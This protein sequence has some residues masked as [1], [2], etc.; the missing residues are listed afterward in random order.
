MNFTAGM[1]WRHIRQRANKLALKR[2]HGLC[3]CCDF[4]QTKVRQMGLTV[5]IHQNIAGLQITVE[6]STPMGMFH[7]HHR[8]SHKLDDLVH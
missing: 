1:L 8:R 4:R 6:H 2:S 3:V 7:S 5:T